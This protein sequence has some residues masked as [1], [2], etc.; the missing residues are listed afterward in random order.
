MH[1]HNRVGMKDRK[2]TVG[3]ARGWDRMM[4]QARPNWTALGKVV[5]ADS[6]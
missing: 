1:W 5:I 4:R 2:N 3:G 6:F